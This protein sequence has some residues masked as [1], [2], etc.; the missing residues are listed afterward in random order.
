MSPPYTFHRAVTFSKRKKKRPQSR[1]FSNAYVS[2]PMPGCFLHMIRSGWCFDMS[3]EEIKV[4]VISTC[5]VRPTASCVHWRHHCYATKV[6]ARTSGCSL[7]N[8]SAVI[9]LANVLY[10]C[11]VG[12]SSGSVRCVL[13][14]DIRCGGVQEDVRC[15]FFFVFESERCQQHRISR[16]FS[17]T[18]LWGW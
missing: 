17:C 10:M 5:S 11:V 9:P 18:Q 6:H 15:V 12:K 14:V 1:S 4:C 7:S 13:G 2:I 16:I 8:A 3:K